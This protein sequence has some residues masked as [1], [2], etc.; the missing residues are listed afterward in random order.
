LG[1]DVAGP[2]ISPSTGRWF[3][4]FPVRYPVFADLRQPARAHH[5][6]RLHEDRYDCGNIA[7]MALAPIDASIA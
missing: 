7:T 5:A 3:L 1:D 2:F 4:I 6:P